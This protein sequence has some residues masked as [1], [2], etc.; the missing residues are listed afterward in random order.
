MILANGMLSYKKTVIR[1]KDPHVTCAECSGVEIHRSFPSIMLA[2]RRCQ[3]ML[4]RK[5]RLFVVASGFPARPSPWS[6]FMQHARC[7]RMCTG[8]QMP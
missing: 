5:P 1:V 3:G 2:Q 6:G 8:V 7:M 4:N